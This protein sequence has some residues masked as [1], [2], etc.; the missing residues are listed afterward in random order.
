MALDTQAECT[1]Q[2]DTSAAIFASFSHLFLSNQSFPDSI[3][4]IKF[5]LLPLQYY[6]NIAQRVHSWH[7]SLWQLIMWHWDPHGGRG[8]LKLSLRAE[9]LGQ[10]Q[11]TCTSEQ[12]CCPLIFLWPGW[13]LP[14]EPQIWACSSK[15]QT[16]ATFCLLLSPRIF[17][18][19]RSYMHPW[20]TGPLKK[21]R[22][23]DSSSQ[24]VSTLL[25]NLEQ[26]SKS[27]DF[28]IYQMRFS[29]NCQHF[30][31]LVGRLNH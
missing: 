29:N 6:S 17:Y 12:V 11:L 16:W 13:F 23:P 3:T 7:T 9:V 4:S 14:T 21:T 26:V 22:R 5:S 1:G 8:L 24:A 27:L 10:N 25:C 2:P 20:N 19:V 18:S 30:A 15:K 31:S 28:F